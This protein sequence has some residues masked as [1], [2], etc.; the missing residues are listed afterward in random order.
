MIVCPRCEAEVDVSSLLTPTTPAC[1]PDLPDVILVSQAGHVCN[2]VQVQANVL[3]A[4]ADLDGR[5]HG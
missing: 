5:L 2:E 1:L 3:S 4:M